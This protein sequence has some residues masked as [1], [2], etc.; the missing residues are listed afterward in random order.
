MNNVTRNQTR[1]QPT[2]GNTRLD[3][4]KHPIGEHLVAIDWLDFRGLLCPTKILEFFDWV[5]NQC[6]D[7]IDWS[8]ERPA[9]RHVRFSCGFKSVR[10]GIYAYEHTEGASHIWISLPSTAL[11]GCGGTMAVLFI[12]AQCASLG[13]R[14]T[15]LDL[16]L[17]D[18]TGVLPEIRAR[19]K[20]AYASGH[21]TGFK[22]L[23]E[24]SHQDS[25]NAPTQETLYIGSRESSSYHRIYDKGDR[26]RWERQTGRDI[27]DTILADLLRIHEES[28]KKL[29][30]PDYGKAIAEGILS[31]LTNGIDFLE[32]K[33]KN[34]SRGNRCAF[35]QGFLDWLGAIQVKIV[36]STPTPL[37][38]KTM[39]WF[40]RQV[41]KSMSLI[42]D[43]L[44]F[45]YPQWLSGLLETG[46]A[47][48]RSI[49][50]SKIDL[51]KVVSVF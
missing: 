26:V 32:R 51:H 47:K 14:C 29:S 27:A 31:H 15:R 35:W 28:R 34:L 25:W 9:G 12:A 40:D 2:R 37:M 39:Q 20:Q 10:G 5:A 8:N 41:S 22:K 7:L 19:I 45:G 36:R 18:E 46:R 50:R 13:L 38:E 24:Y 3:S 4:Q 33:D 1:L 30:M 17:D 44:G 21:H 23:T 16:C 49:D 11:A 43:I 6:D 42:R 48:Y